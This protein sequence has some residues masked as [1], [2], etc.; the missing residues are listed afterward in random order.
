MNRRS[1][2]PAVNKCRLSLRESSVL[3]F[4]RGA[5]DDNKWPHDAKSLRLIVVVLIVIATKSVTAE[6]AAKSSTTEKFRG[7]LLSAVDVTSDRLGKLKEDGLTSIVLLVEGT[8]KKEAETQRGA[9]ELVAASGL[10]LHYWIE[11]ARCSELADA[12]PEWMASLQTHD[13]WQ[14]FFPDTP[15]PAADE[16][17]KT[18]PWVPILARQPFQAQLLR[19]KTLLAD[20]PDP[21]SVF[22]NDLQGAPSACGCGNTLCRWTSDYGKKRTTVPL[23]DDAATLFVN[24]VKAV[25]PNSSVIPVWT[26]ECEK[27]DGAEDGLCAGVGCFDGICWKAYTKQLMPLQQASERL[28][29]LAP[30]REF[31]RDL[32]VYGEKAGW[33]RYAIESFAKMPPQHGGTEIPA[34][35]LIAVLQGWDVKASEVEAQVRMANESGACGYIIAYEKIEQS[36]Q[37]K[38]VRWR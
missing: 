18:Y 1:K 14:R 5:K 11:V 10:E 3:R 28:A 32:P 22:L 12:H 29:V 15:K 13:E 9:A 31:Q 34:S 2:P 27:H 36:W 7:A 24:A 38:V 26:T 21:V 33:V 16:V 19:V 4:F 37:P 23:G 20:Q 30:F 8:S 35:R 25:L 6:E 17:A